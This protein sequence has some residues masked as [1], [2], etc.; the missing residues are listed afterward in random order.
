MKKRM[1]GVSKIYNKLKGRIYEQGYSVNEIAKALNQSQV[2]ISY[3]LHGKVKWKQ[4]DI[5][6]LMELLSIEKDEVEKYFN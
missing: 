2:N 3:K 1:K 6:K 5:D 4:K